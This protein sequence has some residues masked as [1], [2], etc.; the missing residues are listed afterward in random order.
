MCGLSNAK[1]TFLN[2]GLECKGA[3]FLPLQSHAAIS[4]AHLPKANGPAPSPHPAPKPHRHT[5]VKQ[6]QNWQETR[7]A[8]RKSSLSD[9][10][11]IDRFSFV[12]AD[13]AKNCTYVQSEKTIR[14]L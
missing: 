8:H 13:V 4:I 1:K 7:L 11:I 3:N 6:F 10:G 9:A 14:R 12:K 5:H 2:G